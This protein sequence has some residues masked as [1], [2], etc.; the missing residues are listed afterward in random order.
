MAPPGRARAETAETVERLR[1]LGYI[2]GGTAATRESY[3]E[4]DDPK[5]LIEL[6]QTHA[7]R[8]RRPAQPAATGEAIELVSQRHRKAAG[9]RGCVSQ[10][11]ADLLAQPA[12][13][14]RRSRRSSPRSRNG[15]TQ[16]EV[17]NKLGQ[18]LAESGQAQRAIALLEHDAGDD[19]DALVA[20]GNA[21]QLAGR[22]A[23]ALAAFHHIVD[24]DPASGLGY[25]NV[26]IAQLQ[27]GNLPAAEE[28]LRKALELEPTLGGAHT[29]LGVVLASTARKA[30]A[31]DE[32][33]RAIEL[34][35]SD[36][37]ALFNLTLN[38]A[39]TGRTQEA[40]SYGERFIAAAPPAMRED[41]AAVRKAI[42]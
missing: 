38:L 39:E 19:P 3:T 42:R 36:L 16:S 21:Y 4:A 20:L 33:K 17:R 12:S 9:H 2:G 25:E 37:N 8:R 6:E 5:R 1:S 18:Y 7:A 11:R 40:R 41:V 31:I 27:A 29:A 34:D 24:V 28:A 32:W 35:G 14:A 10:A 26:G 30:D 13:R 22:R 23:D 15:V